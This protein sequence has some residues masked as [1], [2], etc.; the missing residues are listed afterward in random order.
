MVSGKKNSHIGWIVAVIM[1]I[2][3][4]L[5]AFV[6]FL[7]MVLTG[8]KEKLEVILVQFASPSGH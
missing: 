8:F 6:P 7:F 3:W 4:L 5:I 1:A 2:F